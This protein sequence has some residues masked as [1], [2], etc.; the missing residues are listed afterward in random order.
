MNELRAS[1]GFKGDTGYSAYEIALENGFVGSEQ[2]WLASIGQSSHLEKE[3]IILTSTEANQ[4]IFYIQDR[5]LLRSNTFCEVYINGLKLNSEEYRMS[6]YSGDTD[7]TALRLNTP[8]E[9]IGTT[10]EITAKSL[11][12][13]DLPISTTISEFSTNSTAAGTKSVYD[14]LQALPSNVYEVRENFNEIA[15]GG[16]TSLYFSYPEGLDGW[17]SFV[18]SKGINTNTTIAMYDGSATDLTWEGQ[19]LPIID[20]VEL[21]THS[22]KVRIKNYGEETSPNGEAI[23]FLMKL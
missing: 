23:L 6:L 20:S 9:V 22:I 2:D 11:T 8:L 1:L 16:T 7:G 17:S 12:T 3:E 19:P 14:A 4:S 18:I 5:N 21:Y 10:V 15:P 13:N